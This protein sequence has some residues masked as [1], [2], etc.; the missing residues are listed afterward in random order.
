ML[1]PAQQGRL[2]GGRDLK[3]GDLVVITGG[4]RGITAEVAVA[5]AS[6]FRPRLVVLGRS[7]AP[8]PEEVWVA[9]I[10][11][12][13]DLKRALT[14]RS[15][16][17]LTPHD[18]N[19]ESRRLLAEREVRRNLKRIAG[20]G[21]PVVYESV[22]VRDADLVRAVVTRVQHEFG[23][24]RGLV[25]GAGVL[26]DRKIVD[27]TDA[28]FDSVYATKV[29]GLHHLWGAID[30]DSLSLLVLFSSSS[31]R[32]GRAG[33]VA[34]A[35]ANEYLNKWAQQ[36]ALLL[37]SCRV[38]SFNWGPWAGGMVTDALKP[39]F[40]QEGL[41]LIPLDTGAKLVALEARRSEGS[42]VELVVVA[43]QGRIEAPN[44]AAPAAVPLAPASEELHTVF[45]REV[46]LESVPVLSAHVIDGHPV[47]PVALILEWMAEAAV[48]RNPGLLVCGVDDFRL[49]KG[50]I[51]GHQKP[52][53]VELKAGK[54]VRRAAQFEVPVELCGTLAS[55]KEV[56]HARAVIVLGDRH[57]VSGPRIGEPEMS[58]YVLL[59]DEIYQTVLFHGP[60]MQGI[61][62]VEG[63]G[64]RGIAGWVSTAPSTSLWIDRPLRSKWLID[65][66]AIDSA[67]QLVGLWTRE[68]LGANSLPTGLARLRL[69][70][71]EIPEQGARVLVLIEQSSPA[72]ATA[73]IEI[74][75]EECRLIARLESFECV[76]DA[77][78]NK[79]FRRNQLSSQFSVVSS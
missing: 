23:P 28:Q 58:A 67:F 63:C 56:I 24:V 70:R 45:R 7:P 79:A 43:E 60:L 64:E 16:R 20:A 62:S 69:F 21:S 41:S 61:E 12:E 71:P 72:R 11:D 47:L 42:A 30:P 75:D 26:A 35:A 37:P 49:F 10:D 33:Q 17:R 57:E 25:H 54:P 51:L 36:Q 9:G 38:V 14:A 76:I 8:G 6:A 34:Y 27:Q 52:S 3:P 48:H 68:T 74:L 5:L 66:L 22:D 4:G 40:E 55:G 32:F 59:R 46:D 53:A 78:L 39:M 19:Q 31:A 73:S 13:A 15:E 29:D 18:L 50:V 1:V 44:R 65:P 77:S 2:P